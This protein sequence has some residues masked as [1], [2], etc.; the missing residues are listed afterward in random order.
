MLL[1][2]ELGVMLRASERWWRM[3]STARL[4]TMT[5]ER[6]RWS[7]LNCKS[8]TMSSIYYH[9]Y[10]QYHEKRKLQIL[11]DSTHLLFF[12]WPASVVFHSFCCLAQSVAFLIYNGVFYGSLAIVSRTLHSKI[13]LSIICHLCNRRHISLHQMEW[14]VFLIISLLRCWFQSKS[15]KFLYED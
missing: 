1:L 13:T 7:Y 15:L 8:L 10:Y 5:R 4:A 9:T 6:W 3:A 2:T 14:S 12:E 11:K